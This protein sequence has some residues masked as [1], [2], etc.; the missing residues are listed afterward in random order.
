MD[1]PIT[2]PRTGPTTLTNHETG[3]TVEHVY[4]DGRRYY[5]VRRPALNSNGWTV[6]QH[7]RYLD[8]ARQAAVRHV[9]DVAR[10]ANA[11][12]YAEATAED[13]ERA[14]RALNAACGAGLVKDDRAA[15]LAAHLDTAREALAQGAENRAHTLAR[16]V[17]TE[18]DRLRA[19]T[20][21]E[22][23]QRQW[24][25]RVRAYRRTIGCGLRAA[26]DAVKAQDEALAYLHEALTAVGVGRIVG[27]LGD[28]AYLST[29]YSRVR[30][31]RS[32]AVAMNVAEAAI[33][34][35]LDADQLGRLLTA[36]AWARRAA[37]DHIDG[38]EP[39]LE[40]LV[41]V[42]DLGGLADRVDQVREQYRR[43]DLRTQEATNV[44][45]DELRVTVEGAVA[46]LS[47][48]STAEL[49]DA[50]CGAHHG[51]H[52]RSVCRR[53]PGHADQIGHTAVRF[54]EGTAEYAAYAAKLRTELI[55]FRNGEIV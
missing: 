18:V 47:A 48:T 23:R 29:E 53:P 8:I 34:K 32:H 25:S 36:R 10:R 24:E 43:G 46:L 16:L 28:A 20:E 1:R 4:A 33:A 15:D 54:P 30:Q 39:D 13:V 35:D 52:G 12:A 44:L 50:E 51:H 55:K 6:I 49:A 14:Q 26:Q 31:Y 40:A 37:D 5:E 27:A 17:T 2:F 22:E 21:R 19:G 41:P 7:A 3:V 45:I 9:A 38:V 42:G 11:T